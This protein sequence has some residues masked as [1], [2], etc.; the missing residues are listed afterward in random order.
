MKSL[1]RVA[2]YC[3]S[4][5]WWMQ[6]ERPTMLFVPSP[7]VLAYFSGVVMRGSAADQTGI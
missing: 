1:D 5:S 2:S 4:S 7:F 6:Y 3:S